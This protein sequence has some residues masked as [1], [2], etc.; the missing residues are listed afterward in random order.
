MYFSGQVSKKSHGLGVWKRGSQA[1]CRMSEQTALWCEWRHRLL[2]HGGRPRHGMKG[3]GE[4]R[5]GGMRCGEACLG[6]TNERMP[7]MTENRARDLCIACTKLAQA[8]EEPWRP[9]TAR[10]NLGNTAE[11]PGHVQVIHVI[12]TDAAHREVLVVPHGD[13]SALQ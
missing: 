7:T 6:N 8:N 4:A 1:G 10:L 5:A 11:L 12:L 3:I 13:R 2:S 9:L